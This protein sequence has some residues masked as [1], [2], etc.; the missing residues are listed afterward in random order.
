MTDPM[1]D[2]M[3][4]TTASTGVGPATVRQFAAA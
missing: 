1:T 2:T 3:T 4:E